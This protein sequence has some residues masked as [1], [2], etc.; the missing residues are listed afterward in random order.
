MKNRQYDKQSC[1]LLSAIRYLT[2]AVD[3]KDPYTYGHMDR[4]ARYCMKIL[5]HLPEKRD[6]NE[7]RERL[8][9]AAL[10]HDVGKIKT[11]PE[12]LLKKGRLEPTETLEMRMHSIHSESILGA[13]ALKSRIGLI[14]RAHHEKLNGTGYPD[15][16]TAEAIPLEARI[17]HVADVFDARTSGRIYR[18]KAKTDAYRDVISEFEEFAGQGEVDAQVVRALKQAY[19]NCELQMVKASSYSRVLTPKVALSGGD[20]RPVFLIAQAILAESLA[21]LSKKLKT[22]EPSARQDL[23]TIRIRVL[24][25]LATLSN[26]QGLAND[27][28]KYLARIKATNLLPDYQNK[29][30]IQK[31]Y[32]YREL[33]NLKH[34]L[35]LAKSIPDRSLPPWF[36][37]ALYILLAKLYLEYNEMDKVTLYL[38]KARRVILKMQQERNAELLCSPLGAYLKWWNPDRIAWMLGNLELIK[39]RQIIKEGKKHARQSCL[40]T[41]DFF[42]MHSQILPA[43]NGRMLLGCILSAEGDFAKAIFY[44]EREIK[45][46]NLLGDQNGKLLRT[47]HLTE[48]YIRQAFCNQENLRT[49]ESYHEA[50][51]L[52]KGMEDSHKNIPPDLHC[53]L[54]MLRALLFHYAGCGKAAE[55]QA[56]KLLQFYAAH[57]DPGY[58]EAVLMAH[59]V[60]AV[61]QSSALSVFT[62]L[63]EQAKQHYLP[64]RQLE[65]LSRAS[66]LYPSDTSLR[67]IVSALRD[68]LGSPLWLLLTDSI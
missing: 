30:L 15:G 10:L 50:L 23:E 1:S 24:I 7:F 26:L 51:K 40:Q 34:S 31:A 62:D 2:E 11:P 45:L 58:I 64:L 14:V 18:K 4:V 63:A 29:I 13:G 16:L 9:T 67:D 8:V 6:D 53:R 68:K 5:D 37:A 60:I 42:E 38:T 3:S 54:L 52:L 39:T 27:A 33:G 12:I 65:I 17:I 32:A 43:S 21:V 41:I 48:A 22:A 44:F 20:K 25:R 46:A 56:R 19:E 49:G 57:T 66:S 61:H 28:L 35:S 36:R 59:F 47:L 55:Y